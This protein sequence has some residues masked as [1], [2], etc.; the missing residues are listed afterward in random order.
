MELRIQQFA[1]FGL[2]AAALTGCSQQ[3]LLSALGQQGGGNPTATYLFPHPSDWSNTHVSFYAESGKAL[4]GTNKD[5]ATCHSQQAQQALSSQQA[6]K[7]QGPSL[8]VSCSTNCHA[9]STSAAREKYKIAR[10][11]PTLAPNNE[12][13]ACHADTIGNGAFEFSHY[14]SGAGLCKTCHEADASHLASGSKQGVTTKQNNED[15]YRCHFPK[16]DKA[17]VHPLLLKDKASCVACHNPHGA[18]RR[19]FL[20]EK[21]NGALCQKCH[22]GIATAKVQ[23]GPV[24][25]EQSCL[26]CHEAHSSSQ[27]KLLNYNQQTLCLT[28]HN[29]EVQVTQADG[30]VSR[31]I[32][33]MADKL[34]SEN[35]HTAIKKFN[36]TGCHS[37]HSTENERLLVSNYSTSNYN[38]FDAVTPSSGPYAL[39][40]KCHDAGMFNKDIV[41]PETNFRD[42]TKNLHWFHVVDATG[43]KDKRNGRSCRVCHDPHG[44]SQSANITGSWKMKNFDVTVEYKTT[45]QG[46][47]C[48]NTCHNSRSYLRN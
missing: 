37:P 47:T 4:V 20:R 44:S 45:P 7:L 8:N 24:N 17:N 22:T 5:C 43:Q 13:S 40:F 32:P 21:T 48:T 35:I 11:K 29:Q 14:P 42:G 28:C 1:L 9:P 3:R 15:C 23:H 16:D 34:Q 2:L 46:G 6:M 39:C 33:N 27:P 30:S 41:G 26:S 31:T 38:A 19:Y 12:C 25:S 36:C 10:I 18:D